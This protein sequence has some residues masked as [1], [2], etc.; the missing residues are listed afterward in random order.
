[1]DPNNTSFNKPSD[2]LAFKD[3]EE[4]KESLNQVQDLRLQMN[5]RLGLIALVLLVLFTAGYF[6]YHFLTAGN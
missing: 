6:L 1:M 3:D 2:N 4:K 5:I